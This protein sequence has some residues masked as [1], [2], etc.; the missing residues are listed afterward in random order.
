MRVHQCTARTSAPKTSL[1]L[2]TFD[3]K[4]YSGMA[5][6][7][8][9]INGQVEKEGQ[10]KIRPSGLLPGIGLI[11]T[12]LYRNGEVR[13]FEAHHQRLTD[14][15]QALGLTEHP[16]TSSFFATEVNKTTVGMSGAS[17]RL[18][19]QTGPDANGKIGWWLQAGP[20][21]VAPSPPISL[22]IA[23]T[24]IRYAHPLAALKSTERQC[25]YLAG[26]EAKAQ[27][28]DDA[29]LLNQH[30]RVVESTIAN[31]FWIKDGQLY[32][33]ALTEGCVAGIFRKQVLR[34]AMALES[35]IGPEALLQVEELFLTNALRGIIP[36]RELNGHA[37]P[38]TQT[39][40][41]QKESEH[42]V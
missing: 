8:S 11:E 29:L 36:V 17:L 15:L 26:Q 41:L 10:T 30:G 24:A 19:L 9:N 27:G 25:F 31:L 28:L 3:S 32:T 40:A 37:F 23:Q 42:W 21:V 18:R 34:H 12:M 13:F 22:S 7:V 5:Y 1:D 35:E 6:T 2:L 14:G 20:M 4:I 39:M 33:P 38:T 16:W